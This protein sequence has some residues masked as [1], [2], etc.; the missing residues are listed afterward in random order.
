MIWNSVDFRVPARGTQ[1]HVI[2][3]LPDQLVTDDRILPATVQDGYAVA[4]PQRDVLKMAVIERFHASG[5]MGHG[6]IQGFGL[7]HGAMAGTFAHDHHNMVVIGADDTS[8]WTAARAVA[9]LGGGLV[10]SD[11]SHVVASLPLPVGGLMSDQPV[12]EVRRCYDTLLA[13]AASRGSQMHDP[14]VAMSFMAL[15]VIPKLKLTD[16]GLVDVEKFAIVDLF[17][18]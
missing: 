2:G 12:A 17:V 13:A 16:Q 10:V 6:F 9:D 3:S 11:G 7:R 15:E 8:M 18:S 14:F 4:D 5:A 1:I